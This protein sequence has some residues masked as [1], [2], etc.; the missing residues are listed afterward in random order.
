VT[1]YSTFSSCDRGCYKKHYK[2]KRPVVYHKKKPRCHYVKPRSR[3][4]Y[5]VEVYY[6]T[7]GYPAPC[8]M[9][10]CRTRC[11]TCCGGATRPRADFVT[12]SGEPVSRYSAYT[13]CGSCRSNY[14]QDQRTADDIYGDMNIDN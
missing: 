3:S 8:C 4:S 1:E 9:S 7:Y 6:T 13:N 11:T 2:K 10:G 12:Y 14:Y 5:K